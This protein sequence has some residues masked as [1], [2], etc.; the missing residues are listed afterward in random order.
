M[1]SLDI[2]D[3]DGTLFKNPLDTPETRKL[4]EKATG[5]PWVIDK[6][7]ARELSAKHKKFIGMRNG[8]HGRRETLEPPLVPDPVP[9]DR[10][11][12]EAVEAFL[13]SKADPD[14]LTLMMTG[15]HAGLQSQVLRIMAQGKLC[16]VKEK[17]DKQGEIRRTCQD[18][19]LQLLFLGMDGPAPH[20]VGAKP[21]TTLP[22][23][24]WIIEQYIKLY[25]DLPLVRIWEDREEHVSEF[26]LL[27]ELY[28]GTVEFEVTHITA[29]K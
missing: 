29:W 9:A 28:L 3:F 19:D 12:P 22:W 1:K 15:R 16:Q 5:L 21:S 4:Y 24:T 10:W 2:F 18:A 11:I 8:W 14:R 17:H 7:L 26:K 6:K 20:L 25:P 13:A 27:G 23:K